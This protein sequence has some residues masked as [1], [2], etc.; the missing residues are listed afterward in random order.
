MVQHSRPITRLLAF[1]GIIKSMWRARKVTLYFDDFFIQEQIAERL[2][3]FG[4]VTEEDF[5]MY[6]GVQKRYL[7]DWRETLFRLF[8]GD[9]TYYGKE[10]EKKI[11]KIFRKG[12]LVRFQKQYNAVDD[13]LEKSIQLNRIEKI[14]INNIDYLRIRKEGREFTRWGYFLN[15]ISKEFEKLFGTLGTLGIGTVVG[16]VVGFLFKT[17]L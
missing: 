9:A 15:E 1:L 5:F 13:A 10:G 7:E 11:P 17:Y 2:T 14:I 8:Y 12:H 3:N 4:Y 6:L 16:I